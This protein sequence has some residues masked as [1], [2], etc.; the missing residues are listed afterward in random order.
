MEHEDNQEQ[1]INQKK[2][3]SQENDNPNPKKRGRRILSWLLIIIFLIISSLCLQQWFLDLEAQAIVIARRTANANSNIQNGNEEK[4]AP[5]KIAPSSTMVPSNTPTEINEDN[6][7]LT[8][9]ISAQLT[10]VAEFQKSITP[11]N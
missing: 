9:T 5:E 10:N 8:A 3:I 6:L 2:R 7:I 11:E 4:A 1:P